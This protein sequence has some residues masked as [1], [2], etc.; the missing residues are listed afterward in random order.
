MTILQ[1]T[2]TASD[3]L[4]KIKEVCSEIVLPQLW[5]SIMTVWIKFENVLHISEYFPFFFFLRLN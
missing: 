5:G 3:K 2:V 4:D 1:Y